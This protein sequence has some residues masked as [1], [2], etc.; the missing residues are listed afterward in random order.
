VPSRAKVV[1]SLSVNNLPSLE[2]E[3]LTPECPI[4]ETPDYTPEPLVGPAF[5]DRREALGALSS[6]ILFEERDY[7][8]RFCMTP[9]LRLL[10]NRDAVA[11]NLETSSLRRDELN[12]RN[13]KSFANLG[14]QTGGPRF[15][16]SERAV[17]DGDFHGISSSYCEGAAYC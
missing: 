5:P 10:V 1:K 9:R 14:R 3:V 6:G 11:Q 7:F 15:V 4:Y 12:R 17:L 13:R 16:V 8:S 2:D